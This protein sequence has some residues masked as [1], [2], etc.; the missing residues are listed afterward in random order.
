MKEVL[1]QATTVT[2]VTSSTTK[3]TQIFQNLGVT[4]KFCTPD[5]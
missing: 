5:L 3:I 2:T 4:S 1:Q